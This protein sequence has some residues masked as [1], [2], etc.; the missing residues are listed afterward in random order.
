MDPKIAVSDTMGTKPIKFPPNILYILYTRTYL[1]ICG[2]ASEVFHCMRL[3]LFQL[4]SQSEPR[5][6]GGKA[7]FVL[8]GHAFISFDQ[9]YPTTFSSWICADFLN[10][11]RHIG[12]T[13]RSSQA[14]N[15]AQKCLIYRLTF[16]NNMD[17][18]ND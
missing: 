8:R 12:D 14:G 10:F 1:Q 18:T 15:L 2:C 9:W 17:R 7:E 5:G 3:R 16:D 4:P 13:Y 11:Y 6:R